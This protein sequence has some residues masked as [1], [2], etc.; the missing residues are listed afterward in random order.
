MTMKRVLSVLMSSLIIFTQLAAC[1]PKATT[2]SALD[3]RIKNDEGEDDE[4]GGDEGGGD[5]G[6]GGEGEGDEGGEGLDPDRIDTDGNGNP[7]PEGTDATGGS[8]TSDSVRS[9]SEKFDVGERVYFDDGNGGTFSAVVESACN[10]CEVNGV[11][12]ERFHQFNPNS[13][14]RQGEPGP[15]GAAVAD[16]EPMTKESQEFFEDKEE[17]PKKEGKAPDSPK[18]KKP[19]AVTQ[20]SVNPPSKQNALRE[21]ME[22]ERTS[23]TEAIDKSVK[24]SSGARPGAEG[25]T[26]DYTKA[27]NDGIGDLSNALPGAKS[28][29]KSGPLKTPADSPLGAA[30]QNTQRYIDFVETEGNGDPKLTGLARRTLKKADE[31]AQEGDLTGA[32]MRRQA[33]QDLADAASCQGCKPPPRGSKPPKDIDEAP[34][35][36]ANEER[37]F[38]Y[39]LG[40]DLYDAANDLDDKG[41]PNVANET[42]K[43]AAKVMNVALGLA[44][45]SNLFDIPLSAAEAFGGVTL[46][47]DDDGNPR[48]REAT[49]I[50]QAV[51]VV[52]LAIIAGATV[53]GA[54]IGGVVAAGV[55]GGIGKAV[56]NAA[57]GRALKKAGTEATEKGIV[58]AEKE[59]LEKAAAEGAEGNADDVVKEASDLG[60]T[61]S[62]SKSREIKIFDNVGSAINGNYEKVASKSVP[63]K[64]GELLDALKD[65]SP[66]PWEKV[67]EAGLL[68][69]EKVEI[70]YFKDVPTGKVFDV[71]KKYDKWHQREFKKI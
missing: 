59:A 3:S 9:E 16:S 34:P 29:G 55:I 41:L 36:D 49:K 71:K 46:E 57:K 5:E 32:D 43:A 60:E 4:G 35:F 18:E 24:K 26:K 6:E 56:R 2:R 8:Y 48:L 69:G 42:R 15:G 10:N 13:I 21:F 44:R 66:G 31:K 19:G 14:E 37:A 64:H 47:I 52:S 12:Y 51:A 1:G 7:I 20:E 38:S 65:T 39:D 63:M 27:H 30:M 50:E 58:G 61:L 33:A 25:S 23:I 70:H 28:R 67:Y 54:G 68:N 17:G 62:R 40:I 22:N 45:I 11:H 53:M